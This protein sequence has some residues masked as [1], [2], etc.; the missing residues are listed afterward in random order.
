LHSGF[1]LLA[2]DAL[3]TEKH[4]V[5]RTIVMI[6]ARRSRQDSAAFVNG[7][8]R[9]DESAGAFAWAVRGLFAQVSDGNGGAHDIVAFLIG[10]V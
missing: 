6:L 1:E 10:F 4:V 7:A 3:E 2:G 8:A 5:Q 9:D